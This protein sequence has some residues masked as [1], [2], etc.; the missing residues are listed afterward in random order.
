[1]SVVE[2][3]VAAGEVLE[4]TAAAVVAAVAAWVYDL[5]YTF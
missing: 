5:R 1:V 2:L 3:V 4:V